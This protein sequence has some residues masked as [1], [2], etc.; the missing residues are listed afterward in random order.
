MKTVLPVRERVATR[1]GSFLVNPRL[2]ATLT[3]SF[4][5]SLSLIYFTGF[6]IVNPIPV[7]WPSIH[8]TGQSSPRS[9]RQLMRQ[10]P[11]VLIPARL[12]RLLRLDEQYRLGHAGRGDTIALIEEP[13][14]LDMTGINAFDRQFGLPRPVILTEDSPGAGKDNAEE[15]LDIEWV[16]TIAPQ[17]RIA[18]I[19]LPDTLSAGVL[20]FLPW[21]QVARDI[22]RLNPTVVSTSVILNG[23]QATAALRQF[24]LVGAEALSEAPFFAAAGDSGPAAT[25]PGML[26]GVISVGGVSLTPAGSLTGPRVWPGT[27][28][29]YDWLSFAQPSYQDK[30]VPSPWR[31]TPDVAFVAG[32]PGYAINIGGVWTAGMGASFAAPILAALWATEMPDQLTANQ[33][34]SLLYRYQ[35]TP[36]VFSDLGGP[37]SSYAGLGVPDFRRLGMHVQDQPVAGFP[38][39]QY[40]GSIYFFMA[41]VLSLMVIMAVSLSTEAKWAAAFLNFLIMLMAFL[42]IGPFS[43]LFTSVDPLSPVLHYRIVAL[44]LS[45]LYVGVFTAAPVLV[46]FSGLSA[47]LDGYIGRGSIDT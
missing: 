37:W 7:S 41:M 14:R 33:A 10:D 9:Y 42:S 26:P 15:T 28:G 4:I 6:D 43:S 25:F 1:L 30:A 35:G 44:I 45:G 17:A 5:F 3:A 39:G 18:V 19:T 36:G 32:F 46:S 27:A 38:P 13:S 12:W 24:S 23:W 16:H 29:G 11:S 40:E 21:L 20:P 47:R 8:V 2:I 22:R 34:V 31:A